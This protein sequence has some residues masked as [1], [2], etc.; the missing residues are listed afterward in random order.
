[1]P[2]A[3]LATPDTAS[4]ATH[5]PSM[6]RSRARTPSSMARAIRYGGS[7]SRT[8]HVVPNVAPSGT[9]QRWRFTSHQR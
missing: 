7:I 3:E 6:P 9:R 8:I 4:N 2:I 5:R 1:M